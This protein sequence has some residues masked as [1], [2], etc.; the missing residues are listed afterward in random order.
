LA[1]IAS[2][3]SMS[4]RTGRKEGYHPFPGEKGARLVRSTKE[5]RKKR[6]KD[7]YVVLTHQ[8]LGTTD[9][10]AMGA[11]EKKNQA[12]EGRGGKPLRSDRNESP[13]EERGITVTLLGIEKSGHI[14]LPCMSEKKKGDAWYQK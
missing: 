1:D 14:L 9:E 8:P 13:E 7:N 10:L 6:R 5:E 3:K 4:I 11:E 2:A 12:H